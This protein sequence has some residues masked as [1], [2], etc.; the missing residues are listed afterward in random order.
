M[1]VKIKVEEIVR[2]SAHLGRNKKHTLFIFVT[3]NFVERLEESLSEEH[4]KASLIALFMPALTVTQIGR[5]LH[6]FHNMAKHSIFGDHLFGEIDQKAALTLLSNIKAGIIDRVA[7]SLRRGNSGE[8]TGTSPT[9]ATSSFRNPMGRSSS[10]PTSNSPPPPPSSQSQNSLTV[11]PR[12]GSMEKVSG[13]EQQ[14]LD[15]TVPISSRSSSSNQLSVI[16]TGSNSGSVTPMETQ[17]QQ[18]EVVDSN[19]LQ[20]RFTLNTDDIKLVFV[21][22]SN[23]FVK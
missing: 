23:C 3:P 19:L 20:V 21:L 10:L 16:G 2:A 5:L 4:S 15:L 18:Q 8:N 1:T 9:D 6:V 12:S 22:G 14:A 7:E 13:K 17:S 11:P